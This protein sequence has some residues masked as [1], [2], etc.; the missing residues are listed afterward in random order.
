MSK[1]SKAASKAASKGAA[2]AD[3]DGFEPFVKTRHMRAVVTACGHGGIADDKAKSHTRKMTT[4]AK[5][6]LKKDGFGFFVFRVQG[7]TPCPGLA[8]CATGD[9]PS[10][11]A[12]YNAEVSLLL[13]QGDSGIDTPHKMLESG[14]L[15]GL[16]GTIGEKIREIDVQSLVKYA[17][18][19]DD[20]DTHP[21][22]LFSLSD[23]YKIFTPAKP[24]PED[25]RLI[26]AYR[27]SGE[28][29]RACEA[30]AAKLPRRPAIGGIHNK[31]FFKSY[32]LFC[33]DSTDDIDKSQWCLTSATVKTH[34]VKKAEYH[35]LEHEELFNL[36]NKSNIEAV[37]NM[38]G[39]RNGFLLR[40]ETKANVSYKPIEK[41]GWDS[42]RDN[43]DGPVQ[44]F[45][46]AAFHQEVSYHDIISIWS[47]GFKYDEVL[48]VDV[49][50][51]SPSEKDDW[52]HSEAMEVRTASEVVRDQTD[53]TVGGYDNSD[54]E[55]DSS[56]SSSASS[57]SSASPH[58]NGG[59][60]KSPSPPPSRAKS[61]SPPPPPSRAKSP[62]P[63]PSRAKG[64]PKKGG[65]RLTNRSKSYQK[66]SKHLKTTR[67]RLSRNKKN[68]TRRKR[69]TR[70]R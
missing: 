15:E 42:F 9:A 52:D 63:P 53:R 64:G 65:T 50:C 58:A 46:H 21:P 7:T 41:K 38:I 17:E 48:F 61:P 31:V 24:P 10:N 45:L 30:S 37:V 19:P 55:S 40:K 35:S 39:W 32:G 12:Q 66:T 69:Y 47:E 4:A 34:K 54:D 43:L 1:A 18:N 70:R 27:N 68:N 51:N 36:F 14:N 29:L 11:F 20:K 33:I 25:H 28:L 8:W 49:A 16:A 59:P 5:G 56:A 67:K 2:A 57:A 3:D 23:Y 62:S 22:D 44:K 26:A 6:A 60:A 13:Q